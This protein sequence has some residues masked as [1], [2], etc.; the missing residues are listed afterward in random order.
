[1]RPLFGQEMVGR[2]K[3][4]RTNRIVVG[5]GYG[6]RSRLAEVIGV[7]ATDLHGDN[8][9]GLT[10][11]VVNSRHGRPSGRLVRSKRKRSRLATPQHPTGLGPHQVNA[12]G[13]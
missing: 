13:Q 11:G 9:F 1:M 10:C 2:G 5:H 7:A 4:S 3:Q 8:A 12:E 6:R